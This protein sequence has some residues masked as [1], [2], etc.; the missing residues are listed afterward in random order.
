MIFPATC[1]ACGAERKFIEFKVEPCGPHADS[2]DRQYGFRCMTCK[3]VVPQ[4]RDSTGR[5]H[6]WQQ[7]Q[8]V[9]A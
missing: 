8:H 1:T 5:D 2:R 6:A 9:E 4:I 3:T 7:G